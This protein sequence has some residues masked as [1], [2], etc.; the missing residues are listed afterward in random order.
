MAG[1]I[2]A[3]SP[4]IARNFTPTAR[5]AAATPVD[6]TVAKNAL[7]VTIFNLHSLSAAG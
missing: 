3:A 4:S 5:P 6:P 7:R 1:S 2:G